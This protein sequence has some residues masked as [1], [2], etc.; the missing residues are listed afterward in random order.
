M[1]TLQAVL[2]T[3]AESAKPAGGAAIGEVIGATVGALVATSA[4]FLLIYL[5]RTD[6]SQVL[7][8]VAAFSERVSGMPGWVA[9]PSALGTGSLLVAL[10]G[11]Y[12][13]I[14]LHINIGRDEGPLANPA[15]YLILVGLFGIF[16][17]GCLAVSLP[18]GDKPT[19][20]AIR[21][22]EGWYAPV[23]GILMALAGGYALLGF[24]LDDMWHRIFGQD[25][26]LWGPTHLM[27]IGGAGMTLI[28]Q[29]ILLR[30]GRPTNTGQGPARFITQFRRVAAMG[31]LLIGLCTFQAEFDFGVPQF[32]LVYQPILIAVAAGV[33]L[34]AARVWI[35]PGAALG[36]VAFFLVVRGAVS[37]IVGPG[38]GETTPALPL[39]I[40]AG[41]AVELAALLI[42][43][44]RPI[45]LGA[46]GGLLIGTVGFWAEYAWTQLVFTLPWNTAFL[47]EALIASAIAGTAAGLIGGLLGAGLRGELPKASTGR[48]VFAASLLTVMAIIGTYLV[49]SEPKGWQA[50]VQLT[51]TQPAPNREVTAQVRI[52]PAS[53]TDDANWVQMTS[54]QGGGLQV[55]R[56]EETGP[57]TFESTQA[58]PVHGDWKT[59]LRVHKDDKLLGVPVYLPEDTAI[60][61]PEVKAEPQFTRTFVDETEILQRELKDDV[62]GW[63]WVLASLVVLVISLSFILALAWGLSRAAGGASGG[64]RPP[65][66]KRVRTV[67]TPA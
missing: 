51:E 12:W 67:A 43:R 3:A 2:T 10:L 14:A 37:L 24:P 40:G 19:P 8:R 33:A 64:G 39:F 42:S 15:H 29:A 4:L 55:D 25:V 17:A 21:I 35:G 60:P 13:D 45:A 46:V 16:A 18:K 44:D 22:S 50:N 1:Q 6:R 28:G 20:S 32:S 5:H 49:T 66:E 61:A 26:T 11:M 31:G 27:L 47:P 30:E 34:V 63:S 41:V 59:I 23:G 38:F 36:A 57:G 65:R 62:P 58:L 56:L 48:L 53:A 54:W 52:T 7:A 9:F